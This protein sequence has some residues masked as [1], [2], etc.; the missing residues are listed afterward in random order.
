MHPEHNFDHLTACPDCDLLLPKTEAPPRHSLLCPRCGKTLSKRN[1]NS[2]V[3]AL[4]LSLAGLLIYPPAMLLPLM[5]M[6]SFGFSDSANIIDSIVNFYQ[7]GYYQPLTVVW[8]N[9]SSCSDCMSCRSLDQQSA[10]T[11]HKSCFHK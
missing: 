6:K 2:I 8:K 1:S 11:E 5:T 3:K 10:Q 7:N 9:L 4:A